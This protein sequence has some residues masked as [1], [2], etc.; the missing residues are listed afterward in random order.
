MKMRYSA[1][2]AVFPQEHDVI[3]AKGLCSTDTAHMINMFSSFFV[4]A[5]PSIAVV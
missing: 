1:T 5:D 4:R 3:L 2:C